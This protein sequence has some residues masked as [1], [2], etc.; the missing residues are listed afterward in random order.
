MVNGREYDWESVTVNLPSGAVVT[1]SEIK[2][3]DNRAVEMIYGKGA[4]PLSYGR[5]KYEATCSIKVLPSEF[6]TIKRLLADNAAGTVYDHNPFD[7]VV[8]YGNADNE[9]ITDTIPL[10]LLEKLDKGMAEGDTSM[11]IEL[12]LKV[13][14]VI[15][16]NGVPAVKEA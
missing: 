10:C 7:I 12:P 1:L 11:P 2:Y 13:L 9:T 14:G 6:E 15:K 3:G 16:W 5:G 4:K 8:S